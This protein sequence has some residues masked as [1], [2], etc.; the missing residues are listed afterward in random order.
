MVFRDVLAAPQ[1]ELDFRRGIRRSQIVRELLSDL[2]ALSLPAFRLYRWSRFLDRFID[3]LFVLRERFQ[4]AKNVVGGASA[5]FGTLK[6][7]VKSELGVGSGSA[8]PSARSWLRGPKSRR[9]GAENVGI[10]EGTCIRTPY[11]RSGLPWR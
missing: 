2:T 1:V 5:L 9:N 11:V 4:G 7:V 10:R 3:R 6:N 8:P